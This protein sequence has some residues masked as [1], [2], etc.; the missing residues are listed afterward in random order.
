MSCEGRITMEMYLQFHLYKFAV[1]RFKHKTSLLWTLMGFTVADSYGK[2]QV[3]MNAITAHWTLN[4]VQF[5][6]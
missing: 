5:C 1:I 3:Y 2:R 4:F 6:L